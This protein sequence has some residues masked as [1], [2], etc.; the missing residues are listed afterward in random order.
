MTVGGG[1]LPGRFAVQSSSAST[2]ASRATV[3]LPLPSQPAMILPPAVSG[4]QE[5][6]T[7]SNAVT[8]RSSKE[9][10]SG[11]SGMPTARAMRCSAFTASSSRVGF[12]VRSER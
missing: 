6:E 5:F 4:V 8:A 1:A 3:P 10:T 2:A 9:S 7:L 11:F 12:K